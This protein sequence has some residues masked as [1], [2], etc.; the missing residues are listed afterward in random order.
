MNAGRVEVSVRNVLAGLCLASA[1]IP[2][3]AAAGTLAMPLAAEKTAQYWT[4]ER[5]A[6]A[7]PLVSEGVEDAAIADAVVEESAN[8]PAGGVSAEGRGPSVVAGRASLQTRLFDLSMADLAAAG[9][10]RDSLTEPASASGAFFTSGRL[11][12]ASADLSYPYSTIGKLF[13]TIPGVGN[14]Y[15]SASVIRPRVVATAAQCLHSGKP[16]TSFYSN[17]Q[18]VPAYRSGVAQLGSWTGV[19]GFVSST[20]TNGNGNLPNAADYVLIEVSDLVINGVTRKLGDITGYLGYA[21]LK[22][23]PNHAH[24]LGY[25]STF[26]SAERAH[27]VTAQAFRAASQNN[28]E[29]GSDMRGGSAGAAIIQDFGDNPATVKWIGAISYFYTATTTKLQGAS[30]PDTRFTGLLNSACTHRLGNC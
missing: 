5:Y 21:T 14:F 1:L 24:I 29:Y 13:F 3:A 16:N 8:V 26:D 25:T 6:S 27:Q 10:D 20:W 7:R 23:R 9:E 22:L 28:A 15:C 4:A 2:A 17:V 18:F 11:V 30:T 19:F 12:P